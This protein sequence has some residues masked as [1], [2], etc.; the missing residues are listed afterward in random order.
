MAVLIKRD[1]NR[2]NPFLGYGC[3][4]TLEELVIEDK[5]QYRCQP[6]LIIDHINHYKKQQHTEFLCGNLEL[7]CYSCN[8]KKAKI[9]NQANLCIELLAS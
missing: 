7:L 2:C 5:S 9:E 8:N 6:Y 3:G 1:G 4:K